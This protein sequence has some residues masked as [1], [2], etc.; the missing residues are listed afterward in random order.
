MTKEGFKFGFGL[1]VGYEVAKHLNEILGEL[2]SIY[3]N[4]KTK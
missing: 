4:N 3:K 1:F 2:Y